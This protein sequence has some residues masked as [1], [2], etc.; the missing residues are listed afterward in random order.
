M[1]V[2]QH[3]KRSVHSIDSEAEYHALLQQKMGMSAQQL[4]PFRARVH[5][6]AESAS[7]P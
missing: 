1:I 2:T 7:S 3:G 5:A 4:P 6:P